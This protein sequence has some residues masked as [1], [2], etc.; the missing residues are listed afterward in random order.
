MFL[1]CLAFGEKHGSAITCFSGADF[2]L[3]FLLYHTQWRLSRG[4]S[5]FQEFFLLKPRTIH[6]RGSLFFWAVTPLDTYYYSTLSGICQE[7]FSNFFE[8]FF[9]VHRRPLSVI[10]LLGV[11]VIYPLDTYYYSRFFEKV[12]RFSQIIYLQTCARARKDCSAWVYRPPNFVSLFITFFHTRLRRNLASCS[13]WSELQLLNLSIADCCHSTCPCVLA[14]GVT[15][16]TLPALRSSTGELSDTPRALFGQCV[17]LLGA[18]TPSLSFAAE[19]I[20][21]QKSRPVN[22]CGGLSPGLF[23]LLRASPHVSQPVLF[24]QSPNYLRQELATWAQERNS[25]ACL[26]R[27]SSLNLLGGR[28]DLNSQF[29]VTTSA[30]CSGCPHLHLHYSIDLRGCQEGF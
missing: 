16:T 9:L 27:I 4:F 18:A 25:L 6:P 23:R 7:V 12:N 10:D 20:G 2:L 14:S 15:A 11:N 8:I 1:F 13:Y 29:P 17:N 3:T 30:C 28:R 24:G 21:K 26:P 22:F 5:L 19:R